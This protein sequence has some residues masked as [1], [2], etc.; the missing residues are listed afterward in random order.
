[1]RPMAAAMS[2]DP[3]RTGAS[4]SGIVSKRGGSVLIVKRA[5]SRAGV[6]SSHRSGHDAGERARLLVGVMGAER[7]Q[8]V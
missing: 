6:T 2:I 5:G 7:H 1:M 8:D 4:G 3:V